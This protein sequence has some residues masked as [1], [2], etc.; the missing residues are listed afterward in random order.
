[1]KQMNDET[2]KQNTDNQLNELQFK[3]DK[4]DFSSVYVFNKDIDVN[5]IFFKEL[6]ALPA[7]CKKG[8]AIFYNSKLYICTV[9]GTSPTF[10]VIGTQT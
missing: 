8:K 7:Q 10:V 1:M 5:G 9:G 2:P 6:S 3:S 4:G